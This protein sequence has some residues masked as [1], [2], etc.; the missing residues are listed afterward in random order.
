MHTCTDWERYQPTLLDS[1]E[2]SKGMFAFTLNL[3][4]DLEGRSWLTC[5]L[6]TSS[7]LTVKTEYFQH[8]SD[9]V[10]HQRHKTMACVRPSCS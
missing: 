1:A 5:A 4:T 2:M 10:W 3:T 6:A 7:S 8:L 9:S